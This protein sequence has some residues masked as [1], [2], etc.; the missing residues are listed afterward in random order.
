MWGVSSENSEEANKK[1]SLRNY[2][3]ASSFMENPGPSQL[4]GR[5][6]GMNPGLPVYEKDI[7]KA[8]EQ[9]KSMAQ[10]NVFDRAGSRKT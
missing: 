4:I 2:S 1:M 6:Q 3:V 7:W 5:H 9:R 8:A 10:L